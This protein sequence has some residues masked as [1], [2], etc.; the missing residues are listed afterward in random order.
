M[1][2]EL[3]EKAG[4][5]LREA[6]S[7]G[8]A[9]VVW[10]HPQEKAHGDATTSI[11]LQLA[12]KVQRKPDEVARTLCAGLSGYA[13]IERVEVAGAGY[14]NVWLT[15]QALLRALQMTEEA[16]SPSATRNGEG[17]VIIDY[18]QPNIAKPLGVHHIL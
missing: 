3:A 5:V 9:T 4:A 11:A 17:P 18:S 15:P 10:G 2:E 14:V 1:F 16:C 8:E 7:L 13:D 6:Y 12:K